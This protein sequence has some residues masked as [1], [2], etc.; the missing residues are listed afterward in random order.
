MT[1]ELGNNNNKFIN[2]KRLNNI[3]YGTKEKS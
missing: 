3:N 2:F 1:D